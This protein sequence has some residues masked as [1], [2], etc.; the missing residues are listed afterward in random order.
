MACVQAV[1]PKELKVYSSI[2][3]AFA[4]IA[5]GL[6]SAVQ[7]VS[8]TALRQS[9]GQIL[10]WPSFLYALDLLAWDVFLGHFLSCVQFFT[11]ASDSGKRF[12]REC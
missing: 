8:L 9:R 3:L 2:A 1:T 10:A 11:V 5:A 4:I 7:F 12:A 6:T